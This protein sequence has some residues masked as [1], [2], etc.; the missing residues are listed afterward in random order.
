MPPIF[1]KEQLALAHTHRS[2]NAC[3]R[4]CLGRLSGNSVGHKI[5]SIDQYGDAKKDLTVDTMTEAVK[6]AVSSSKKELKTTSEHVKLKHTESFYNEDGR[7]Q[8]DFE[9]CP[10]CFQYLYDCSSR[11]YD[12]MKQSAK[13]TEVLSQKIETI[14]HRYGI[15][16][17]KRKVDNVEKDSHFSNVLDAR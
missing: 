16:S 1:S 13:V 15:K 17:K 4:N 14:S 10:C 9:F 12:R 3:K 6:N 7:E 2:V 8:K 11:Q 5:L